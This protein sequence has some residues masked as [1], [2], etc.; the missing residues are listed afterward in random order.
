MCSIDAPHGV[1]EWSLSGLTPAPGR[2]VKPSR[3]AESVFSIECKLMYLHDFYNSYGEN[4]GC[5]VV[6]EGIWFHVR[7]DA[8]AN[9]EQTILRPE[10]MKAVSRLGGITYARTTQ[11]YELPT[12]SFAR[13][14]SFARWG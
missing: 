11:G 2:Q 3:V 4:T 13:Y 14:L 6:L 8:F 12:P 1:S 9:E 10:V 7:E 5:M